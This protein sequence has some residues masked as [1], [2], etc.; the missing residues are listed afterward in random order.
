MECK[1]VQCD[2][3]ITYCELYLCSRDDGEL[4][5][6]SWDNRDV[7]DINS[8]EWKVLYCDNNIN[9]AENGLVKYYKNA[10][11]AESSKIWESYENY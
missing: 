6:L 7:D 3:L 9:M 2:D 1:D 11:K 10:N 5:F 4:P 8:V